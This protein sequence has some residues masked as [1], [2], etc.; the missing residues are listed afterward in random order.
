MVNVTPI[1]NRTVRVLHIIRATRSRG[2]RPALCRHTAWQRRRPNSAMRSTW[3][4]TGIGPPANMVRHT[5]GFPASEQVRR[6]S[7]GAAGTLGTADGPRCS[8]ENTIDDPDVRPG[9]PARDVAPSPLDIRSC[10]KE[11]RRALHRHPAW[12]ARSL[13]SA[14]EI[15]G[16]SESP[17]RS[18]GDECSIGPPSCTS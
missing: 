6:H 8:P 15:A 11:T 1:R 10:R 17:W 3:H 18:V 5:A 14:A 2:G 12:H 9:P 4:I 16:R 7:T 13:V